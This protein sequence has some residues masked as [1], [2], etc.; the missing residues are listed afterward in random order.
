MIANLEFVL[1]EEELSFRTAIDG[2]KWRAVVED[3]DEWLRTQIK[4]NN[5]PWQEIRDKLLEMIEDSGVSIE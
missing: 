4:H 5:K 1:P 3:L 2:R